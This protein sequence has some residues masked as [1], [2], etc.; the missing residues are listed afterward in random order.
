MDYIDTN[1]LSEHIIAFLG[2]AR[3]T[4]IYYRILRDQRIARYKQQSVSNCLNRLQKKGLVENSK[5]GWKLTTLGK[6]TRENPTL[7]DFV[8]S[9]F[10]SISPKHTI[11]AFD[12]PETDRPKRVWLRNQLKIFGYKMIQQSLWKGPG[13]LP[14]EFSSRLQKLG[15]K[16]SV[17][18]FRVVASSNKR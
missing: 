10:T 15:I 4:R 6:E 13:P 3:N 1:T 8:P 18:I 17:K 7:F 14:K 11:V 12:I 2:S 9:P 5:N 16:A